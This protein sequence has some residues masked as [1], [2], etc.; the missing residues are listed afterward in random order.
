[1]SALLVAPRFARSAGR[2]SE[3]RKLANAGQPSLRFPIFSLP[4]AGCKPARD[5][6][7]TPLRLE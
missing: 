5:Q 2:R 7:R 6:S 3:E 4:Y 1:V